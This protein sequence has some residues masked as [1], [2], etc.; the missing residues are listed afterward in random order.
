[1]ACDLRSLLADRDRSCPPRTRGSWC[2]ADPARTERFRSRGGVRTVVGDHCPRGQ[3][4]E[5][6]AASGAP[7]PLALPRQGSQKV[8]YMAT[9]LRFDAPLVTVLAW[10]HVPRPCPGSGGRDLRCLEGRVER[11]QTA[12]RTQATAPGGW[13][14]GRAGRTR[15]T[16]ALDPER[17]ATPAQSQDRDDHQRYST[18]KRATR[19]LA[20][21]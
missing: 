19:S 13:H 7:G 20:P 3:A 12:P 6:G 2:R 14:D 15:R 9:D 5:G 10:G 18:W 16:R 4:A 21:C 11:R 1:M 8:S 17:S